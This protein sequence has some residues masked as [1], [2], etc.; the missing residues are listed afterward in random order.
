MH[1][2]LWMSDYTPASQVLLTQLDP[3][4]G[5]TAAYALEIIPERIFKPELVQMADP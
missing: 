1:G 2:R 5:T 3:R 4:T